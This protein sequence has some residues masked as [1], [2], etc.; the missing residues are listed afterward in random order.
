MSAAADPK[1]QRAP[2][3]IAGL[4]AADEHFADEAEAE[5]A[6]L[7]R[8]ADV[9]IANGFRWLRFDPELER[10]FEDDGVEQRLRHFV[11][12]GAICLV[13]Y[14]GFLLCDWFMVPD[15]FATAVL[16]RLGVFTPLAL[17]LL[18]AGHLYKFQVP[19]LH[20][21]R[22]SINVRE[23]V[24]AATGLLSAITLVIII[25]LSRSP[26]APLYHGGLVVVVMYGCVVQRL[27]FRF[28]SALAL[29]IYALHLGSI[30]LSPPLR[31]PLRVPLDLFLFVIIAFTLVANYRL[32]RDERMRYLLRCREAALRQRLAQTNVRL[33]RMS[34]LDALTGVANRRHFQDYL[35]YVWTRATGDG[36]VVSL[37]MLD[38]DFFKA[39]NDRYGHP[40][41]DDCLRRIAAALQISLRRPGDLIARFGGEEFIAVLPGTPAAL[42]A[43]AA[44]RVR[45]S[46]EDLRLQHQGSRVGDGIVTVSIGVA[47]A[48]PGSSAA[49][50]EA[51]IAAADQMLYRAKNGG[52]NCVCL[53]ESPV[54]H[55]VDGHRTDGTGSAHRDAAHR[56]DH[57]YDA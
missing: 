21:L 27:R 20:T 42:A 14:D 7:G 53:S 30:L 9:Q 22:D 43:R 44:E 16:I 17:L 56:H 37:M 41:G 40:A 35:S 3:S 50:A 57:S 28:A 51:L 12:S 5:I 48:R 49:G 6:E 55:D 1:R 19:L 23:T 39:Y 34:R 11:I 31:F 8:R 32:E 52:R 15:V 46:V 13:A 33:E 2:W 36:A 45:Q 29:A 25:A 26:Y 47:A 18:L 4:G 38:V 24:V 54:P 10:R